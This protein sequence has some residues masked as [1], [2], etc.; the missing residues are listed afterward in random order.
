MKT[1]NKTK[2]I[3]NKLSALVTTV[4]LVIGLTA[5]NTQTDINPPKSVMPG[6]VYEIE[7]KDH[8]QSP[9][10]LESMEAA[11]EGKNLKMEILTF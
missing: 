4:I 5:F 10:K 11:V 3:S 8:E 2:S 1:I 6:V 7:V 9:P